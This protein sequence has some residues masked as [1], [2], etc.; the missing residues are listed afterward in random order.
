MNAHQFNYTNHSVGNATDTNRSI[1]SICGQIIMMVICSL[2]AIQSI[3]CKEAF[4]LGGAE[5]YLAIRYF[6][7]GVCEFKYCLTH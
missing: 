5:F 6:T 7:A 4:W 2:S 1:N 3:V